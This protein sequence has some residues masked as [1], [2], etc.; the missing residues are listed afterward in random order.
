MDMRLPLPPTVRAT[1]SSALSDLGDS[2]VVLASALWE[3]EPSEDSRA[4]ELF[5]G[6]SLD[7]S[8]FGQV[9]VCVAAAS[10]EFN[11][12]ALV[13]GADA[14]FGPSM[15]SLARSCVETLGRAW[16]LVGSSNAAALAHRSEILHVDEA[17]Y[18]AKNGGVAEYRD[19]FGL[20]RQ[21]KGGEIVDYAAKR[22]AARKVEGERGKAPG[23]RELAIG[24]LTAVN[25]PNPGSDY[26]QM[27][28]AAHGE[29]TTLRSFGNIRPGL[30]GVATGGLNLPVTHAQLYIWIL[31]HTIDRV[32]ET[33]FQMWGPASDDVHCQWVR[34]VRDCQAT[35][36]QTLDGLTKIE[37]YP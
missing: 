1:L 32:L 26:S 28:G 22:L 19:A 16:W 29:A 6:L 17:S 13:L 18:L 23:Y 27:S 10:D 3:I 12:F 30:T 5:G 24:L 31:V 2:L 4:L 25:S 7:S 21:L 35:I 9:T 8:K 20:K 14:A 15:A 36:E 37:G 33:L 34:A 11:A